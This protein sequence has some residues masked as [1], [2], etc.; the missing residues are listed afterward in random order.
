MEGYIFRDIM[1]QSVESRPMFQ[2]TM[3]PPS[4]GLKSKPSRK[5]ASFLL[6][7]CCF[8]AWITIKA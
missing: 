1:P 8:S 6:A 5:P 2:N 7:I 4:S 3:S